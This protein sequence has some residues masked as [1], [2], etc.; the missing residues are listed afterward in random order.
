MAV[1]WHET[2]DAAVL[3]ISAADLPPARFASKRF[4]DAGMRKASTGPLE[5]GFD[6]HPS[7]QTSSPLKQQ[8]ENP[9]SDWNYE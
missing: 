9:H 3:A 1:G 2:R 4:G 7:L 5:H 6:G 8:L